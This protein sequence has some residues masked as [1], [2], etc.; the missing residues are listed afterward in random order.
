MTF[1]LAL[2]LM[3]LLLGAGPTW[4]SYTASSSN[5]AL[6]TFRLYSPDSS[7]PRTVYLGNP[8]SFLSYPEKNEKMIINRGLLKR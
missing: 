8:G 6:D 4:H 2:A 5:V 1:N 3:G 7:D